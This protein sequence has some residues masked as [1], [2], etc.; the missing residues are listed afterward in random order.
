MMPVPSINSA[1]MRAAPAMSSGAC[2]VELVTDYTEF[3]ALER[4]WN[5]TVSRA[6]VMHP[7]LRHEWVR[8]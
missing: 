4:A 8:T 1:P 3:L 6:D 5:D 7:F 2:G